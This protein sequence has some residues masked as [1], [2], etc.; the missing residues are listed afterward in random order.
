MRELGLRLGS[1]RALAVPQ[2]MMEMRRRGQLR[3]TDPED[4]LRQPHGVHA[5]VTELPAKAE[6][7]SLTPVA[8]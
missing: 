3:A 6:E 4:R 2:F 1:E 5:A 7:P 8:V